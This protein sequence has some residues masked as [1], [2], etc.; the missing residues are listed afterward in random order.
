MRITRIIL[1]IHI[2]CESVKTEKSEK[3]FLR[4]LEFSAS[5]YTFAQNSAMPYTLEYLKIMTRCIQ[6]GKEIVYG[7]ADRKFCSEACKNEYH[8][9]RRYPYKGDVHAVILRKIDLNYAILDR[10]YGMGVRTVDLITLSQLGFDAQFVTSY[11]RM[12]R[13]NFCAI[14]DLQY[15]LTESRIKRLIC[16]VP[17]KSR[18]A[19]PSASGDL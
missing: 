19:R 1:V 13:R 11:R 5:F 14:Y 2:S 10:L 15:E 12:G 8:N 3:C 7:R 4:S 9:R 17:D 6:C 16:L 18:R